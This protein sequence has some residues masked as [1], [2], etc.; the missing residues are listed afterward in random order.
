MYHLHALLYLCRRFRGDVRVIVAVEAES[1]LYGHYTLLTVALYAL[2][3]GG[4]HIDEHGRER[5]RVHV[6]VVVESLKL[7]VVL[8]ND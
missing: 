6:T 4:W 1:D 8:V 5:E 7:S 2:P 3:L